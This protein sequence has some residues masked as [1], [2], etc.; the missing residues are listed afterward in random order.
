MADWATPTLATIY[1]TFLTNLSDR[2]IDSGTMFAVAATNIPD[3]IKRWNASTSIF[4]TYTLGTLSWSA[5]VLELA[6]GGTGSTTASGARTNLG[7]GTMAVQASTSVSIT[8]GAISGLTNFSITG[9]FSAGSTITTT[10]A[11][12]DSIKTSGGITAGG[13]VPIINVSGKIPA[14]SSVYFADLS[15]A[16]LTGLGS[17]AWSGLTGTPPNVSIFANNVPYITTSGLN[18]AIATYT[19]AFTTSIIPATDDAYFIGSA[20]KIISGIYTNNIYS[21]SISATTSSYNPIVIDT[22][23]GRFYRKTNG[24]SGSAAGSGAFLYVA[25]TVE[26]GIVTDLDI[27]S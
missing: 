9:T 12:A 15:G 24:F 11:A 7:L 6:G 5:M 13:T 17:T 18:T 10:S 1:S 25:I 26:N 23:D 27:T 3:K 19:S 20:S 14:I 22:T 2:V 8:G 16:N 4:E 21:I